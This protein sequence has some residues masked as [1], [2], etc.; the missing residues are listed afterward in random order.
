MVYAL[1][2]LS[3]RQWAGF[4]QTEAIGLPLGLIGFTLIWRATAGREADPA[5]ARLLAVIGLFAISVALMAR[6]GPFF[7]L[8]ALAIWC[9]WRLVPA[10]VRW[11]E[12]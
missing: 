2:L 12:R 3:E 1:L 6:A 8:P 10:E 5:K 11:P 4:V 7:I 9:A